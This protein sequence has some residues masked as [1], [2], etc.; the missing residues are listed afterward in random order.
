M[1]ARVRVRLT[2]RAGT[3]AIDGFDAEGILHARVTAAPSDGAAND[4]LMRLLAKR[5]GI[6]KTR[7]RITAGATARVK[8]V[9]FG[10]WDD[11]TLRARLSGG[12]G[13]S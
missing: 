10:H 2:P 6:A 1:C 8:T 12:E 3:D 11:A 7:V 13:A 9:E 4:A 5:A